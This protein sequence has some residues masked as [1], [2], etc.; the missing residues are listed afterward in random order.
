MK[1][2]NKVLGILVIFII[3]LTS[4]CG[5]DDY[6]LDESGN[7]IV[8]QATGQSVQK[9]ILCQ[10][11]KDS[12]LYKIYES[13]NEQLKTKL[14]D[15]PACKDFSLSSNEY[16]GLWDTILVKPL[17]LIILKFGYLFNNFG[18]AVMLVG[19]LIR[20]ILMPLSLK[21]MRQSN[22]MQKAQPEI[23]R[24]EKK[25]KDK[26][27]SDSMMAKSQE[28]MMIYQ[29]YKINPVSGCLVALLQIPLFFAFL[30]AI[31]KVPAIFE[32]ELFGMNLGMTPWKGL[33]QGEYIYIVL[34][35]L[36][37]ATTYVSFKNTMKQGQN[38]E[39]MKQM[40]FM[41]MF[42]II[43]IS[44]ASFSLPTAIAFYWIVTNGFAVVQNF[45]IKKILNKDD[46]KTDKKVI[47]VKP[48][49]KK[50]KKAKKEVK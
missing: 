19:L 16:T 37:V 34:I 5:K 15:L 33:S 47:E 42:M 22:N 36:I 30:S 43:S 29:K 13:N 46:N 38:N 2:Q 18:I 17:A 9:D 45:I 39:M 26:T 50:E 20:I 35:F 48:K 11:E 8:D 24:I 28:M 1:K 21:S 14:E 10:P 7:I 4:G 40:N 41:F 6:L 12:D 31:N 44:I 27:D 3:L 32:G 23:A 49:E 25:Y